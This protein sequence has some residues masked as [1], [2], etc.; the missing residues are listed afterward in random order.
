MIGTRLGNWI[1]E[2]ELGRGGMG[3]V[4]L[5]RRAPDLPAEVPADAAIKVLSPALANDAGF[6]HRFQREIDALS[7]LDH[8]NIVRFYQSGHENSHFFYAMEYVAGKNFDEL[9]QEKG[10]LPWRE[11]LDMALHITPALKHAHDHGIIHRDIKPQ[12]LIR[13]ESGIVKLADFGVAKVFASRQLTTTGGL[14]GTAEYISPEQAAG[15]PVTIRSDLYSFGVVLYTLITGRLP[16]QGTSVVDFLQKH[17]FAQFDPPSSY[18]PELPREF[19]EL[20]CALLEKDPANRPPNALALQRLLESLDRKM[21]RK[22]NVTEVSNRLDPTR[23][24]TLGPEELVEPEPGPATLMSRLMRGQLKEMNRQGPVARF[25]NHPAVLVTLLI[26]CIA[27]LTWHFWPTSAEAL[28]ARGEALM[29][30]SDPYDW[31]RAEQDFFTPLDRKFPNHAYGEQIE[32][33][34]KKR[35]EYAATRRGSGGRQSP[36]ATPVH[37]EAERFYLKG[38]RQLKDGDTAAALRTFRSLVLTFDGVEAESAWVRLAKKAQEDLEKKQP[39]DAD[40]WKSVRA[41]LERTRTMKKEDAEPIWRAIEELYK[42][43][44]SAEGVLREVRELRAGKD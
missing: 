25:F 38:Q 44:P 18:L 27:I 10:K 36:G 16:F 31:D 28:F 30:S 32:A 24:D 15:K 23:A 26:G 41:T 19:D 3:A 40:R 17:R 37:S 33:Y 11:V 42:D 1:I 4:Y 34:R 14:V 29:Q 39:P 22:E 7:L 12:N 8:P 35:E 2:K 20:I 21:H 6:L 43:D 13:S 5:G 9:L